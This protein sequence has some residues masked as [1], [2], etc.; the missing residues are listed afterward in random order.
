MATANSSLTWIVQSFSAAS[1]YAQKNNSNSNPKEPWHYG[2]RHKH[3][4]LEN[5]ADAPLKALTS[6]F[7]TLS[8]YFPITWLV[9]QNGGKHTFSWNCWGVAV[10]FLCFFLF[11]VICFCSS[12]MDS[13][14][15]SMLRYFWTWWTCMGKKQDRWARWCAFLNQNK[16]FVPWWSA[17]DWWYIL[18]LCVPIA[19][20]GHYMVLIVFF[21]RFSGTLGI[22]GS[23][24][25][26]NK[27]DAG[28]QGFSPPRA[29]KLASLEMTYVK[30]CHRHW[31]LVGDTYNERWKELDDD[32]DDDDDV[33]D[34]GDFSVLCRLMTWSR[35]HRDP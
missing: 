13:E 6:L 4:P 20:S 10:A 28:C 3:T 2:E 18:T 21:V 23:S 1:F 26:S 33:D 29:T 5:P 22:V 12:E 11:S 8:S 32:D 17:P 30:L 27:N 34:D 25:V 35:T 9:I 24:I 7:E 19:C 14:M 16:M 15:A 31:W